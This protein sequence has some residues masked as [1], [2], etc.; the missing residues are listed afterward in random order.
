MCHIFSDD[1]KRDGLLLGQNLPEFLVSSNDRIGS[2]EENN[3]IKLYCYF[4]SII[5]SGDG[6]FETVAQPD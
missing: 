6:G 2:R 4:E 1:I 5:K 3:L